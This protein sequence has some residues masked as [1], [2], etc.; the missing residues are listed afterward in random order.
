MSIHGRNRNES[1]RLTSI[2]GTEPKCFMGQIFQSFRAHII[3][4]LVQL[5]LMVRKKNSM[6]YNLLYKAGT[7]KG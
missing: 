1:Q 5:L 3:L 6:C 7:Q 4:T 2:K